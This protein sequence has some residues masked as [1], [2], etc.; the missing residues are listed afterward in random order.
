MFNTTF[1]KISM[2][3]L[4]EIEKSVKFIWKH[5]S[6]HVTERITGD[7]IALNVKLFCRTMVTKAI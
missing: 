5:K 4:T 3:L 1:V 2:R 6:P 7:D